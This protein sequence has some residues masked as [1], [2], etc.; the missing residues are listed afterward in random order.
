MLNPLLSRRDLFRLSSGLGLSILLPALDLRAATERG[1]ARPKSLITLWMAGGPSQLE[2]WDPHPGTKIGGPTKAIKTNVEGLSIADHFP[3]MAERMDSV[4]V[5]RSLVSKEGDHERAT[6]M[7]KTGFRPAPA[8]IHPSLSAIVAQKYDEDGCKDLAIP[9]IISFSP[10]QWPARGGF[11]GDQYDA[12]KIFDPKENLHNLAARVQGTRQ[13][14][15]VENLNVVEKSFARKRAQAKATLHEETVKSALTMMTSD[16][17]KAFKIDEEPK[18]VRDAYGDSQFG[19]GCLAARRLVEVGVRAVEVTLDGFDTHADN[20]TGHALRGEK[21]DPAFAALIHD[22]KERDLWD[23]TVVLCIGEFGRTPAINP[24]SGRDH[25]PSGFS[26]VVGGAGFKQGLIIGK[27]DPEGV[28]KMPEDPIEVQDLY[29]TVLKNLGVDF[30]RERMTPIGR[31]MQF[32]AG[33]PID[34]LLA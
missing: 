33:T 14:Q 3:R 34:R 18:A 32:S 11:L 6:Y 17:L 2:T 16:Q 24:F 4:C 12:F 26:A 21:V 5:I 10:N 30:A 19:Q 1:P 7:L 27:T 29:A 23:S 22:L 8:L 9:R 25:W 13:S 31:P 28:A 15:R 20:F